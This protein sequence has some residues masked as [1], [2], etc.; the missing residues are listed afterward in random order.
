MDMICGNGNGTFSVLPDIQ[1]IAELI[2]ESDSA[3]RNELRDEMLE[4]SPKGRTFC[5]SSFIFVIYI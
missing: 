5:S 3:R 4:N 1:M 2:H